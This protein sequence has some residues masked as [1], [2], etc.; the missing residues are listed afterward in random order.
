M[1]ATSSSALMPGGRGL[2]PRAVVDVVVLSGLGISFLNCCRVVRRTAESPQRR[3]PRQAAAR[4]RQRY[5]GI[6]ARE[7][8]PEEAPGCDVAAHDRMI[9]IERSRQHD[10][11]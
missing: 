3:S 7:R 6:I 5:R 9:E 10:G 4:R 11:G 1:A 8:Y 2:A